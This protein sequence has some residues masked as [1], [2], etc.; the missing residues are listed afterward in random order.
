MNLFE[1]LARHCEKLERAAE[2]SHEAER[3]LASV[4]RYASEYKGF[5]GFGHQDRVLVRRELQTKLG[6]PDEPAR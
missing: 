3:L 5:V 6:I 4:K 1:D 2:T